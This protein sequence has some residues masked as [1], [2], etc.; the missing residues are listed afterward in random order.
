M[1][2]ALFVEGRWDR[3][4]IRW[5]LSHLGVENV[6]VAIVGGGVSSLHQVENQIVRSHDKGQR[7]ALLLDA[8]TDVN[9]RRDELQEE[10]RRLGLP[11]ARS[12]LLPDNVGEGELETTRFRIPRRSFMPI[13]KL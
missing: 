11:V 8:D 2:W 6:E 13:A 7:V 4:F 12:F 5:L 3:V 1:S 10:I 9:A